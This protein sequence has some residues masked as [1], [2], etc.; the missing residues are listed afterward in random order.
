[1]MDVLMK[2]LLLRDWM[3][4]RRSRMVFFSSVDVVIQQLAGFYPSIH[5]PLQ[6]IM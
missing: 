2:G 6:I 4:K 5:V 3:A 1:M